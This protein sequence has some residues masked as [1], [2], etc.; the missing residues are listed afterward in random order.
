M[1]F[2]KADLQNGL[3]V[4]G[5][6]NPDA[7]SMAAGY[8]VRTG[9]RDETP[10]IN[11]ASHFLEHM[12]FKGTER[13]TPED[14][15]REFDDMGAQY[16]AFTSEENTVYYGAVLP[17]HQEHVIDLLTDMM[18]PA[19]RES[20]FDLERNVIL[21][22]IAMY[23]DRPRFSVFDYARQAFYPGH[24]LGFSVL[25]TA[26]SIGKLQREQMYAYWSRRYASSNLFLALTGNYDWE[27]AVRQVKHLTGHWRPVEASRDLCAP[28]GAATVR[29]IQNEKFQQA[30]LA[31]VFPGVAAQSEERF[32]A[33]VVA[34]AIGAADGSRFYWKLIEPGRAETARLY[35]SE[36][37]GAGQFFVYAA[38][39]PASA[40]EI[41]DAVREV[42]AE[43]M[44][45]GLTAD[46]IE[47]ARRKIAAGM[48]LE[49]ETPFGRLLHVG[50]D[51]QY[52]RALKPLSEVVDRILAVT[53]AEVEALLAR[54]P[55]AA[56]ALVALGPITE[57]R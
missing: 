35:H 27:R 56:G 47:R 23:Q 49:G 55:F 3:T 19:L 26:E 12:M 43:A 2:Q 1:T 39:S 22:E 24:P 34:E 54:R 31:F 41:A 52:R 57:L 46:E 9:S 45:K 20:D 17:E 14:V 10:E 16:N 29:V 32:A 50:F 4:I 53:P 38:C 8:F 30:H 13:R 44:D 33:E 11:G 21:E 36:E 7:R 6:L 15:N 51:W 40:Q 5:E 37:D 28:A 25:G 18:R 48:V 42:L